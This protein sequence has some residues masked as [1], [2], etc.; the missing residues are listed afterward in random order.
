MGLD[1]NKRGEFKI[2]IPYELRVPL[3]FTL[4]FALIGIVIKSISAGELV[5]IDFFIKDYAA[6]FRSFGGF[7]ERIETKGAEEFF[8]AL[9]KNWYYFLY[10]GWLL[11][12]IWG[13][14][15][16]LMNFEWTVKK[17]QSYEG[18]GSPK[19]FQPKKRIP[20]MED[21]LKKQENIKKNES[22]T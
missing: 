3:I 13:V 5:F 18:F 8:F 14:L 22:S 15:N 9:L 16:W 20:N 2:G 7:V 4:F 17:P 1:L 10:T 19:D 11:S 12:L 6:W 21:L